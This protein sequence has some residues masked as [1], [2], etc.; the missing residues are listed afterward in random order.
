MAILGVECFHPPSSIF[1][2]PGRRVYSLDA[3]CAGCPVGISLRI[4]PPFLRWH[5]GSLSVFEKEEAMTQGFKTQPGILLKQREAV[6][7]SHYQVR[8]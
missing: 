1:L 3:R 6:D 7:D 8:L 2:G 5:C 4:M